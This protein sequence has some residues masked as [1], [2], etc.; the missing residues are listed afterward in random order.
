MRKFF[1]ALLL[2]STSAFASPIETVLHSFDSVTVPNLPGGWSTSATVPANAFKTVSD[3]SYTSANAVFAPDPSTAGVSQ[4]TSP[5]FSFNSPTAPVSFRL[6]F[7]HRYDIEQR[8]ATEAWDGGVVEASING[9]PFQDVLAAGGVFADNGYNRRINSGT[10]PLN[11]R[12]C[13]SGTQTTS[14]QMVNVDFTNL[15][16]STNFIQFRWR[17]GSDNTVARPGWWIDHVQFIPIVDM[18]ITGAPSPTNRVLSGQPAG[19]STSITNQSPFQ[20]GEAS[21][22]LSSFGFPLGA[23]E[24]NRGT[25]TKI[26]PRLALLQM[27]PDMSDPV[28]LESGESLNIAFNLNTSGPRQGAGIAVIAPGAI[29][30]TPFGVELSSIG[31]GGVDDTTLETQLHPGGFDPCSAPPALPGWSPSGKIIIISEPTLPCTAQNAALNLQSLGA[32]AVILLRSNPYIPFDTTPAPGVTIPILVGMVIDS[33][34]YSSFSGIDPLTAPQVRLRY[35]KNI[36]SVQVGVHSTGQ[37]LKTS[38]NF[39][40]LQTFV[41][42]DSDGDGAFDV[43]DQCPADNKKTA[44]AACGCGV[45]DVDANSNGA[46]D[47]LVN[48]EF[49]ALLRSLRSYVNAIRSPRDSASAKRLS[50]LRKKISK[51][52]SAVQAFGVNKGASISISSSSTLSSLLK[53]LKKAH[54]ALKKARTGSEILKAKA[55]LQGATKKIQKVVS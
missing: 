29:N 27:A 51:A 17:L 52:Q 19:F 48:P 33:G 43:D 46:V 11:G 32:Q 25:L 20:I 23:V 28:L 37:D 8:S 40:T 15:P 12:D 35:G 47:C 9:G 22:F 45:L 49:K 18:S 54:A 30:E 44:P 34:I 26:S 42:L 14:F 38:N 53:N 31:G 16:Q 24:F 1:I 55:L 21:L 4:L 2:L 36:G 39:V 10:N 13:Y 7:F 41:L 6:S 50:T 5:V 3:F